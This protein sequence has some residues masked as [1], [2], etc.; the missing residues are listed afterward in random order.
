[1][2]YL[3]IIITLRFTC[4]EKKIWYSIQNSQHVM[5]VVVDGTSN[6]LNVLNATH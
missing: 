5:S 6:N 4:G 1:M 2:P 3:L